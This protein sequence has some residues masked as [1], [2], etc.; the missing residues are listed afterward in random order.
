[1]AAVC[2]EGEREGG[3]EGDRETRGRGR[4]GGRQAGRQAGREGEG[5]TKQSY[6]RN[7]N[8]IKVWADTH[9]ISPHRTVSLKITGQVSRVEDRHYPPQD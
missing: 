8:V 4:E 1:M 5:A 2:R 7:M 9:R 3:R 6:Y